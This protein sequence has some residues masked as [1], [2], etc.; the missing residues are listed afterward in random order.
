MISRDALRDILEW[1]VGSWRR[2]L[3]FWAP[4]LARAGGGRVLDVGGRHGGLSLYY[5]LHGFDVVCTDLHGPSERARQLHERHGVSPRVAYA[6]ADA[7]N[8]PF[9]EA[10]FDIV[11]FKSVLGGLGEGNT[12]ER[13]KR[14][15]DEMHRVLRPGGLLLFA[16]NLAASRLHAWARRKFVGWGARWR[17]VAYD[18]LPLLLASFATVEYSTYGFLATFGRSERQRRALHA[19]DVALLPLIPARYRYIAFGCAVKT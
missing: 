3:D 6:E 15:V 10:E 1:D 12:F 13:Q 17:Y 2:A 8:L 16:E 4:R 14:A 9:A 5:A 19:L 18:E 7:L 11:S